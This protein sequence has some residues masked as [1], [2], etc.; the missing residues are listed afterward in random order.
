[1]AVTVRRLTF[2]DDLGLFGKIVLSSYLALPGHPADAS[3]DNELADVGARVRDGVVFGAFE[4]AVPRGCVTYV[5]DASSPYAEDL[6]DGE[7]SFRML[8]VSTEAQGNGIGEKLVVHCL[9]EARAAGRSAVFIHS[10]DWMTTAHRLYRRLGFVHVPDRDW[11]V[12]EYGIVLLGY[13]H[14]L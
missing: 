6:Q 11:P 9:D 8:G 13:L 12:P 1:V 4:D 5:A 10:G 3:Y 14:S 7:A 2:D